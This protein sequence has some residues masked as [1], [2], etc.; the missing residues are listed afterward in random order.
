MSVMLRY[1]TNENEKQRMNLE[2]TN[3]YPIFYDSKQRCYLYSKK[4]CPKE[5]MEKHEEAMNAFSSAYKN[6][7]N[8]PQFPNSI[9][10]NDLEKILD[11]YGLCNYS[12]ESVSIV[13]DNGNYVPAAILSFNFESGKYG[14]GFIFP[15][16]EALLINKIRTYSSKENAKKYALEIKIMLEKDE[17]EEKNK[18]Y[19]FKPMINKNTQIA[20]SKTKKIK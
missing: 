9:K 14:S 13:N 10:F 5:I 4:E 8:N 18:G 20:C 3:C 7:I 12:V 19:M 15:Q 11:T 1:Q 17:I 2:K 6:S 16:K